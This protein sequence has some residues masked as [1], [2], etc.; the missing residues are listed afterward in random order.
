MTQTSSWMGKFLL[1]NE[2]LASK[3]LTV[4]LCIAVIEC[5]LWRSQH[6]P[7]YCRTDQNQYIES[8]KYHFQSGV[9]QISMHHNSCLTW[10]LEQWVNGKVL[11]PQGGI[12]LGWEPKYVWNF[13]SCHIAQIKLLS[14]IVSEDPL[15]LHQCYLGSEFSIGYDIQDVKL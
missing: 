2:L 9:Q 3:I 6:V 12:W 8:D 5:W 14:R 1:W 15:N 13:Y 4:S 11:F 7:M 10:K